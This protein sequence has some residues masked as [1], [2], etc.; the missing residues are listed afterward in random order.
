MLRPVE[1]Q[2]IDR[3]TRSF[4]IRRMPD[5]SKRFELVEVLV[6]PGRPPIER[7]LGITGSK[8]RCALSAANAALDTAALEGSLPPNYDLG[9]A[10]NE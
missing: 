6:V 8:S 5:R 4:R 2:V 9:D 10:A 3:P 7:P 1:E